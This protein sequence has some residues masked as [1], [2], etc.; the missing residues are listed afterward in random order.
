MYQENIR[1][2]GIVVLLG[3]ITCGIYYFYWIGKTSSA[4]NW[5]IGEEEVNPTLD[6]V[7]SILLCGVWQVYLSYR[8][9]KLILKMQE[10]AGVEK[11]DISVVSLVLGI[12]GLWIV[13]AAL[14]QLELNKV[15][16]SHA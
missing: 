2:P 5:Y 15:W 3:F 16:R 7:L 10:Q 6:V 9:P 1:N 8:Y 4:I 14:I 13:S 12:L 11:N